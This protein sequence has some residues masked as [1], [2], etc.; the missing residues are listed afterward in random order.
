MQRIDEEIV[1]A[2]NTSGEPIGF[3]WR[4]R[5]F[6]V[7]CKPVRWFARREWWVEAARAQRGIGAGVL[8]VEMWRLTAA[9]KEAAEQKATQYEIIH[10]TL[11]GSWRLSRVYS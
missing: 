4:N 3:Q 8:E 5:G 9:C 7:N 11:D 10:S 1:V 2:T 6:L